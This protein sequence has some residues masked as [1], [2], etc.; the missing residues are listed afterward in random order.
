MDFTLS[1]LNEWAKEYKA[2]VTMICRT[3]LHFPRVSKLITYTQKLFLC[4]TM[5]KKMQKTQE[6][7][8]F[9]GSYLG[10]Y[11]TS[12]YN[13]LLTCSLIRTS[14]FYAGSFSQNQKG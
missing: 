1:Q 9:F 7:Q 3:L 8:T 6:K 11:W 13:Q 14:L 12:A 10:V 2:A 5:P 4:L